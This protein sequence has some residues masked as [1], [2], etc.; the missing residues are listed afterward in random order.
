MT[1]DRKDVDWLRSQV[2]KL[3]EDASGQDEPDHAVCVKYAEILFKML[4]KVVGG[5]PG[6]LAD[7]L[8]AARRAVRES[9]REGSG[10]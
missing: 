8:E 3:F 10:R 6:K 5:G 2:V 4:P 9:G 1:D 7:T